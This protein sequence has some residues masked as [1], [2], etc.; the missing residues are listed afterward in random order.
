MKLKLMI[1]LV[2]LALVFGMV[3]TACDD[4]EAPEIK[5]SVKYVGTTR[6]ETTTIYDADLLGTYDKVDKLPD[7]SANPNFGK[8]SDSDD[9]TTKGKVTSGGN[10]S[11][12]APAAFYDGREPSY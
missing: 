8:Y 4:G 1:A 11:Y 3:L 7:G 9:T 5:D 12:K 10:V 2:I 6:I